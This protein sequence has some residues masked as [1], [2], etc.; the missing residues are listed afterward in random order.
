[1]AC[2]TYMHD[3][4]WEAA[5]MLSCRF[6]TRV[7]VP[8]EMIGSMVTVPLPPQ[9]GTTD[10]DAAR[11]RPALLVVDRIEVHLFGWRGQLWLRVSAQVYND[12]SD[13]Q[14]LA[15]AVARRT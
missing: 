4:A 6:G 15:D 2:V 14:R 9:M 13:I 11:L 8:R 3:L 1:E 12:R 7:A 10:E 5:E